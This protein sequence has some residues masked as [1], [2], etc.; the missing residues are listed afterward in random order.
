MCFEP[1]AELQVLNFEK[2]SVF[3]DRYRIWSMTN[4]ITLSRGLIVVSNHWSTEKLCLAMIEDSFQN[5]SSKQYR[6]QTTN[7]RYNVLQYLHQCLKFIDV[8]TEQRW[9]PCLTH[10]FSLVCTSVILYQFIKRLFIIKI[11]HKC[12]FLSYIRFR[13]ILDNVKIVHHNH[14]NEFCAM[15]FCSSMYIE[16][17]SRYWVNR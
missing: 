2:E 16:F 15:H 17:S 9:S 1:H 4:N 8:N 3:R 13:R 5:Y 14:M 7:S 6:Q 10:L 11:C 12:T